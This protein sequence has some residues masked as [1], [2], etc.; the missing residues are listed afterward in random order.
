[1]AKLENEH[2]SDWLY[3]CTGDINENKIANEE[4]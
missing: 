2:E 1:M 3:T 4:E